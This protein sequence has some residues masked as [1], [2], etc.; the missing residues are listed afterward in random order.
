M[1]G[2]QIK[3]N[4]FIEATPSRSIADR[5]LKLKKSLLMLSMLNGME[6]IRV[7][8][9]QTRAPIATEVSLKTYLRSGKK[10]R[11]AKTP[12]KMSLKAF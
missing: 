1:L 3:A 8:V 9:E 5:V 2:W 6:T 10:L 12:K 7:R 4:P 11:A